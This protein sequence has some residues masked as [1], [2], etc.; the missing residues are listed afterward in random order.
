MDIPP[1]FESHATIN[2]AYKLKKSLYGLKLSPRAWFDRFNKT[3]RKYGYSQCQADHKFF[4]KHS[5]E[6]K[7]AILIVYV[8]DIILTGDNEDELFKLETLLAKEFETKD[9]GNLKYFLGMEVAQSK[10][11]ISGHSGNM[12][13]IFLGRQACL[14]VSQLRRL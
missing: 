13:W 8:D 1:G 3:V 10:N 11:G 4:V 2:K 7:I 12:C 5:S 9:L 14:G 6:R